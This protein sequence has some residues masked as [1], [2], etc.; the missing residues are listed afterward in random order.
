M[1]GEGARNLDI[2]H[3]EAMTE[4]I[5]VTSFF[6]GDDGGHHAD[7]HE[8]DDELDGEGR[9]EHLRSLFWHDFVLFDVGFEVAKH[10]QG[11][12]VLTVIELILRRQFLFQ[13]LLSD[14]LA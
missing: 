4:L 10:G 13:F 2:E 12:E 11:N 7:K 5:T 3:G 9:E 8:H 14:G 6:I 1:E